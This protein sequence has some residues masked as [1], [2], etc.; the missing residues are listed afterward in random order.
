MFSIILPVVVSVMATSTP[1]FLLRRHYEQRLESLYQDREKDL[2]RLADQAKQ[3]DTISQLNA[4]YSEALSDSAEKDGQLPAL[5]QEMQSRLTEA[6]KVIELLREELASVQSNS[7]SKSQELGA[8]AARMK[9]EIEGLQRLT[10]TF[11]RWNASMA[12]L[13]GHNHAMIQQSHTFNELTKQIN[14]LALNASIEAARA[15]EAGRGFAVVA[16]EVRN[17]ATQS[18]DVNK[19]YQS[20]LSKNEVITISTFQDVEASS[21]MILTF[22]INLE[23]KVTHL[24]SQL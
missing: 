3:E 11:D 24:A 2:V 12:E 13:M 20:N 8:S 10:N 4:S 18:A 15:G 6:D 7:S 9:D 19:Q 22:V 17:L 16:D 14:M 23:N 5:Q 21:R 1:F